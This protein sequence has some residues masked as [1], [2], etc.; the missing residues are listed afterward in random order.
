MHLASLHRTFVDISVIFLPANTVKICMPHLLHVLLGVLSFFKYQM[1]PS[2]GVVIV[3]TTEKK[4]KSNGI[5]IICNTICIRYFKSMHECVCAYMC[6]LLEET[7]RI[8]MIYLY[9]WHKNASGSGPGSDQ[10]D[11]LPVSDLQ[12]QLH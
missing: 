11:C 8:I 12:R 10:D 4:K 3:W 7:L 5:F 1:I 6:I 2:L 9:I